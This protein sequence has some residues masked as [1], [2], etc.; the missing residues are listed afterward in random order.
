MRRSLIA[1]LFLL[2]AFSA[3]GTSV[4]QSPCPSG[5]SLAFYVMTYTLH[6]QGCSVGDWTYSN[7]TYQLVSF[8]TAGN[9]ADGTLKA[10]AADIMLTPPALV[11]QAFGFSS[12]NFQVFYNENKGVGNTAIYRLGYTID[13]YPPIIPGFEVDMDT[14]TPQGGGVATINTSLCVHQGTPA[15]AETK[16]FDVIYDSGINGQILKTNFVAFT[17][18]NWLDVTHTI[19]LEAL[20]SG[21]SSEITGLRSQVVQADG[22]PFP[23][24]PEPGGFVLAG[25]GLSLVG[26]LRS[27]RK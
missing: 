4:A 6:G 14:F 27:R 17:P 2:G 19:T 22:T 24:V 16:S 10:E 18:T 20:M 5:Q 26:F 15:C 23:S 21:A 9:L 7:F 3:F 1:L 8:P 11:T 13:P 25:L 12:N